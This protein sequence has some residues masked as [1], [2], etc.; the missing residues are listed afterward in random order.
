MGSSFRQP[1]I[2]RSPQLEHIWEDNFGL[3][4]REDFMCRDVSKLDVGVEPRVADCSKHQV[5]PCR[6]IT[7]QKPISLSPELR[8]YRPY[9]LLRLA[10][11]TRFCGWCE[12]PQ[13]STRDPFCALLTTSR[14]PAFAPSI[15][16]VLCIATNGPERGCL[17][18]M[19]FL[20]DVIVAIAEPRRWSEGDAPSQRLLLPAASLAPIRPSSVRDSAASR[21]LVRSSSSRESTLSSKCVHSSSS[22]DVLQRACRQKQRWVAARSRP[23]GTLDAA[24]VSHRRAGPRRGAAEAGTRSHSAVP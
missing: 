15:C 12:P 8:W 11:C 4:L 24:T 3:I 20:W 10:T 17:I 22:K 1:F 14:K 18:C 2:N 5:R 7:R 16:P 19:P 9:S 23:M 13:Q 6:C 21:S